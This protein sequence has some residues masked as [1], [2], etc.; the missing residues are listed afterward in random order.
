MDLNRR[1]QRI[2][3]NKLFEWTAVGVIIASA[4]LLGAKTFELDTRTQIALELIDLG[5]TIFFVLEIT[6][7]FLATPDKKMFFRN[8]WNLFDT[9]SRG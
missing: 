7:R 1:L 8:G 3:D 6:L 9:W 4:L 5:I 2:A